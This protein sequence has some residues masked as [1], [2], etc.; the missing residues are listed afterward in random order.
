VENITE[1]QIIMITIEETEQTD[2]QCMKC[3][4]PYYKASFT[5]WGELAC[6]TCN[7]D[8]SYDALLH[9]MKVP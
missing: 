7:Y 3:G 4:N 1:Q 9:G 5:G 6:K 8:I 2:I